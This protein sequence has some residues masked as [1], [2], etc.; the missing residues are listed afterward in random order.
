MTGLPELSVVYQAV[1]NLEVYSHN[2]RTHSRHQIRQIAASIKTFGF[3]N[4]VLIDHNDTIIAGHGRVEAAKLLGIEK[5]PTIRLES[6]TDA[7]IRAY[8]LAD[9]RLAEKAGWEKSILAIELQH[10][11]TIST[12]L[13]VT[14]T[15]FEVPEI[16]LIIQEAK[17]TK[18]DE[19]DVFNID[20]TA[21][22]VTQSADLWHLGKHRLLCGN[23]LDEPS[24]KALM[25]ARRADLIFVDPPYNVAINGNVSGNGCFRHREFAMGSGEMNE[26]EFV[27]FLTASLRLLSQHST[28]DSVH[29]VC[30]DWRHMAELLAAG[31]QVYGGLLNLCVWVKNN[32]GMGSFYRSRHEL[33]FVF[34]NG[35]G[36]HRNNVQLGR[37]GRNRTNVWEYANA[38]TLSRQTDEGNLIALHPTVK[39]VGMVA[40]ALLDCSAPGEIVLDTFLGSGTT[41]IAA[42]RIGRICHGIEI[43]ALYVDVAIRRWQKLTGECAIHSATGKTFDDIAAR[44]Q[45]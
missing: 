20:E 14:V 30:M 9:N 35:K 2:A 3:T 42:E 25:G 32:D 31:N 18:Q 27:A 24:Y 13:D 44:V 22:A 7:Q 26:S 19:D 11:L 5:V 12:D 38:N 37:F 43:D 1:G 39:P 8:V 4:P 36:R 34:K 29:F 15:G 23:A 28:S 10:L 17:T 6:L 41:L 45:E 21:K 40:D 33:I 16:D